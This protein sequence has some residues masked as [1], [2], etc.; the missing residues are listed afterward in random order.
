MT[1][2]RP[3]LPG[4]RSQPGGGSS[5]RC[6]LVTLTSGWMIRVNPRWKP[7]TALAVPIALA[8]ARFL[9]TSSP[10]IMVTALARDEGDRQSDTVNGAGRNPERLQRGVDQRSDRGLGEVTDEQV[11]DRDPDHGRL[12]AGVERVC[13]PC[14]TPRALAVT[15]I[16]LAV[17]PG[18]VHGDEG[19]FG[20]DEGSAGHDEG[21]GNGKRAAARSSSSAPGT[22][23]RKRLGL[24]PGS[25][26]IQVSARLHP[27]RNYPSRADY[28]S[29]T[30]RSR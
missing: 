4:A 14:R 2:P 3:V 7:W 11:G 24:E 26:S 30:A 12:K 23:L 18:P 1:G 22:R 19:E 5:W 13:S 17:S 15:F 9:G 20:S 21:N 27:V 28:R 6:R 16:G 29:D 25:S 8:I 10:K